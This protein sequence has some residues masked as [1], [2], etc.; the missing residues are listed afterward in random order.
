MLDEDSK[1]LPGAARRR[2]AGKSSR[3]AASVLCPAG[4]GA[5][6]LVTFE[7]NLEAPPVALLA[8]GFLLV[9]I[10]LSGRLPSRLQWETALG[11]A[12]GRRQRVPCS[13]GLDDALE[14]RIP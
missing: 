8:A 5:G 14:A 6:G 1:K 11:E 3:L 9:L 2:E 4:M 7:A 12:G 13:L 10:A